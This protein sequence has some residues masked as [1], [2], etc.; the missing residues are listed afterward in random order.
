[1]DIYNGYVY[2]YVCVCKYIYIYNEISAI[3]NKEIMPLQ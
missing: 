3:K 2:I 1:M